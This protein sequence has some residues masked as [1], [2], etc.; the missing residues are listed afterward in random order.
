[1]LCCLA[2][3][4]NDA[5]SSD[6]RRTD[7]VLDIKTPESQKSLHRLSRNSQFSKGGAAELQGWSGALYPI[8]RRSAAILDGHVV[9]LCGPKINLPRP[10]DFLL[11]IEQ[12]FLPLRDPAGRARNRE[13]HG[14]HRHGEAHRLVDEAGVEIHVG[15]KFARHKVIIFQR[16]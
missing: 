11:R 4:R 14:K 8:Y 5:E 16:D 9:T 2:W 10:R 13:Q 12:H 3:P 6:T 1:M 15:I 7:L